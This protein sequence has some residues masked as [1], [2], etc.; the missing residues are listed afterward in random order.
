MNRQAAVPLARLTE[1]RVDI[2]YDL[3]ET[4][5]DGK[6]IAA[7][8]RVSGSVPTIDQNR[9]KKKAV[10]CREQKAKCNAGFI[11]AEPVRC[12]ES[13]TVK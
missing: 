12:R 4:G 2:C 1:Q 13:S 8:R 7:H 3:I 6:E 11:P 5:F 9:R 10:D